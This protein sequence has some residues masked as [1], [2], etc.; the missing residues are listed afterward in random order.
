M[1]K[2]YKKLIHRTANLNDQQTH[3]KILKLINS[4]KIQ[5]KQWGIT[6]YLLNWQT[7]KRPIKPITG[8]NMGENCL[9]F[10]WKAI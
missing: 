4:K 3:I 1:D 7:F 8:R 9:S 6:L 5:I 10:S 2:V